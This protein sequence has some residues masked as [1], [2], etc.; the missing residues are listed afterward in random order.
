MTGGILFGMGIVPPAGPYDV[1]YR[2]SE[3]KEYATD[4]G[5]G[6]RIGR[7]YIFVGRSEFHG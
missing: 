3:G 7:F 1:F 4:S 2:W 5:I 6:F